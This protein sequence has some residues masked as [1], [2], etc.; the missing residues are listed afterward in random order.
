MTDY[1]KKFEFKESPKEITYIEEKPLELNEDFVF[2]HNKNKVRK[3]LTPLQHLFKNYT[4]NPLLALGI[5][6]SYL[7]EE[8]TDKYLF[9][10]FTTS[11][12]IKDTNNIIS[13]YTD[14]VINQ[15]CFYLETN[16]DYMLLLTKDMD[17]LHS[18]T[19]IMEEILTQ[20]L[21]DYFTRKNFEDF[22]KISQFKMNSC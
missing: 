12:I 11:K 20:V 8:L 18:G 7:E 2:F 3:D 21:E 19:N 13:G 10:I 16:S 14:N 9:I 22:I 6:D 5:R 15:G 17:G 4:Q 1:I